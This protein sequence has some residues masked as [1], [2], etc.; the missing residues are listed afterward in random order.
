MSTIPQNHNVAWVRPPRQARSQE[1]LDRILDAAE[2]VLAERGFEGASVAEIVRRAQSSVGAF[3]A[4]FHD[5]E[6]L[7]GCLHERFC[8]EAIA[9]TDVALDPEHW[10][11][12]S[13]REILQETIPFLTRVYFERPGLIRSFIIRGGNDEKFRESAE[14][15]GR[16]IAERLI[17]LLAA[18][19]DEI[20]HP[21]PLAA[22]QF[23]FGLTL[24]AL[25]ARVLYGNNAIT[26]HLSADDFAKELI[27]MMLTYLGIAPD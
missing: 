17:N 1:T 7:L 20:R 19:Q 8:E 16:Y 15:L 12:A 11:G 26:G 18:R 23:A 10:Q 6:A 4:R 13:I 2:Q 25:D 27:R 21:E 9:T 5:K 22:A 24:S 14:R 3:Y